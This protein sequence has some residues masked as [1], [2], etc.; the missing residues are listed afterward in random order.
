MRQALLFYLIFASGNLAFSEVVPYSIKLT[1]QQTE[2]ANY[3]PQNPFTEIAFSI[4]EG[5][6]L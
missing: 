2:W 1:N 6:G 5:G 3:I 4:R